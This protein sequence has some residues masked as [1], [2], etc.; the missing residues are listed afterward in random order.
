[1]VKLNLC[2]INN[3]KEDIGNINASVSMFLSE[4]PESKAYCYYDDKLTDEI[5]EEFLENDNFIVIDGKKNKGMFNARAAI[6]KKVP[7]S[8]Y[9]VWLDSDDALEIFNLKNLLNENKVEDYDIVGEFRKN[10]M[11]CKVWKSEILKKAYDYV[12]GLEDFYYNISLSEASAI[13]YLF[14]SKIIEA[15][16][17]DTQ[18]KYKIVNYSGYHG[19]PKISSDS[20][21][22]DF[23]TE[24]LANLI[25]QLVVFEI[26]E[27]SYRKFFWMST[28]ELLKLVKKARFLAKLEDTLIEKSL[29]VC[30]KKYQEELRKRVKSYF[31]ERKIELFRER[32]F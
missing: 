29:P 10:E 3:R 28:K 13:N 22:N 5:K 25:S 2:I 6:V 8:E 18:D 15:K 32:A 20:F 23:N 24:R 7:K 1:M 4:F 31:Q 30:G 9:I 14:Y 16:I 21:W 26:T 27:N 12:L 19:I 17:L 11:W